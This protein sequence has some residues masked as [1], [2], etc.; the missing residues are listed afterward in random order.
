MPDFTA[1]RTRVVRAPPLSLCLDF[2]NTRFW[3]GTAQPSEELGDYQSLCAWLRRSGTLDDGTADSLQALDASVAQQLLEAALAARESLYGLLRA[4][5]EAEPPPD[6]VAALQRRLAAAPPR[7]ELVWTARQGGWRVP[8]RSPDA[9]EVLAAVWWSAADLLLAAGRL[10]PRCC[11][12]PRCGWL[13][14]DDSK[15]GTR[16]WCSMSACGNRAKVQRHALRQRRLRP[17][18]R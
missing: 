14:L 3:R 8:M 17:S 11:A 16:R 13:F 6:A 1:A 10:R 4:L 15:G 2:V 9:A 7:R 5:A 12:N 18:S